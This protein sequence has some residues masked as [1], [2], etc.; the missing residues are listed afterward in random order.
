VIAID[1]GPAVTA[2]S[3]LRPDSRPL[4][5]AV[6]AIVAALA[7][8]AFVLSFSAL[9][10]LAVAA[11][12]SVELAWLW[13]L[14][15]DGNI[16]VNTVAGLL[17][18]PR[19]REVSWYPWAALFLFSAVS[20]VGNGLHATTTSGRLALDPVVAFVVS[21]IPA[22]ALLQGS[23]LFVVMLSAPASR[24]EP[25]LAQVGAATRTMPAPTNRQPSTGRDGRG[26]AEVVAVGGM[27]PLPSPAV[28]GDGS[29]SRASGR[30][31]GDLD[32]LRARIDK[33][34]REGR[35]VTG[36][37]VASWLGVSQRTGRR[38]LAD[39]LTS[40]PDLAQRIAPS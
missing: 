16:V 28:N 31:R 33:A 5:Y 32:V 12:V 34:A 30:P 40:N 37:D 25:T 38:R 39:L 8:I 23:H 2:P 36:G 24:P 29:R 26:K 11:H 1:R 13:P 35:R 14:A 22:V 3:L 21:A 20:V 10:D 18:R 17:L 7:A 9:R 15:V 19:G 27:Q 4:L 6:A